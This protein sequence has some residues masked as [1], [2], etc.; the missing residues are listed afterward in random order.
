LRA[1][2]KAIELD[3]KNEEGYILSAIIQRQ[4]GHFEQALNS[5]Q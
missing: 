2:A 1:I 4:Q 3:S 5:L